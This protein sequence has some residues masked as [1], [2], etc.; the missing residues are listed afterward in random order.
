MM[1]ERKNIEIVEG[2]EGGEVDKYIPRYADERRGGGGE[3]R[4]TS[5]AKPVEVGIE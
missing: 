1:S 5:S 2:K 3:V 4:Y